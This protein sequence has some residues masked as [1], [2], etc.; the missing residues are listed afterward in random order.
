MQGVHFNPA[1]AQHKTHKTAE[2]GQ[3]EDLPLRPSPNS[4]TASRKDT[5]PVPMR[6]ISCCPCE[7]GQGTVA[8]WG[9]GAGGGYL[10]PASEEVKAAKAATCQLWAHGQVASAHQLS[11]PSSVK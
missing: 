3:L 6:K 11:G 4:Y 10:L 1:P 7:L 9:M 5:M 2:S 8:S